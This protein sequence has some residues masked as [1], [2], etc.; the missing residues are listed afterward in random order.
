MCGQVE[1]PS[2]IIFE[3]AVVKC[4]WCELREYI[5]WLV[6]PTN[7]SDVN[8]EMFWKGRHDQWLA[9]IIAAAYAG[10]HD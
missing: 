7:I 2:H 3:C 8:I 6:T 10:L 5:G 4:L 9:I 1:S